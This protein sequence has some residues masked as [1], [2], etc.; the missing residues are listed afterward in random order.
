MGTSKVVSSIH[1]LG[2]PR[3]LLVKKDRF[4]TTLHVYGTAFVGRGLVGRGPREMTVSGTAT[5]RR[6]VEEFKFGEALAAVAKC[7]PHC[8]MQASR[9]RDG[10]GLVDMFYHKQI[11]TSCNILAELT[12]GGSSYS[13]G[14]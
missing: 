8:P 6:A 7:A 12:M 13:R 4:S 3:P 11:G 9:G 10:S 5:R 2:D 14:K 1:P